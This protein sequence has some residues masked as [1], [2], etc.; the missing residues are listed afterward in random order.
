MRVEIYGCGTLGSKNMTIKVYNEQE[1]SRREKQFNAWLYMATMFENYDIA[2]LVVSYLRQVIKDEQLPLLDPVICDETCEQML[3]SLSGHSEGQL[4]L[5]RDNNMITRMILVKNIFLCD[6]TDFA[7]AETMIEIDS[8][9]C[10]KVPEFEFLQ[11]YEERKARHPIEL[12][13]CILLGTLLLNLSSV[14]LVVYSHHRDSL[15]GSCLCLLAKHGCDITQKTMRD[16]TLWLS[17]AQ[18]IRVVDCPHCKCKT[19][20]YPF[21]T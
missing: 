13:T 4:M 10:V 9:Y 12:M 19:I 18:S 14:E 7:M 1:A 21:L 2:T 8:L 5:R 16:T 3:E 20:R 11:E 15:F 6:N 17:D